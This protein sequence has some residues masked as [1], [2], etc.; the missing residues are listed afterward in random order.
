MK[1]QAET[2]EDRSLTSMGFF[3]QL[4]LNSHYQNAATVQP[5]PTLHHVELRDLQ[6]SDR[7]SAALVGETNL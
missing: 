6:G 5:I 1:L 3:G 2:T 7:Q 4:G